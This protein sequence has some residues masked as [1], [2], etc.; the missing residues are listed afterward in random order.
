MNRRVSVLVHGA[1]DGSYQWTS[2]L[3]R[4][5][6][7]RLICQGRARAEDAA[8]ERAYRAIEAAEDREER[9]RRDGA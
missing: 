5:G 9:A 2:S 7:A 8:V 6:R 1:P 3:E 4:D